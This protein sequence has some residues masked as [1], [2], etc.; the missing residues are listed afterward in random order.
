[1]TVQ[2]N[3]I[4]YPH[5][6][7]TAKFL[8]FFFSLRGRNLVRQ[9]LRSNGLICRNLRSHSPRTG[10]RNEMKSRIH[11]WKTYFAVIKKNAI[12]NLPCKVSNSRVKRIE[13]FCRKNNFQNDSQIGIP[14]LLL[15]CSQ[16]NTRIHG[17]SLDT[18]F[19]NVWILTQETNLLF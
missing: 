18:F 16:R 8:R 5:L 2:T 10:Q 19:P 7:N 9:L 11:L 13:K 3:I 1:M 15:I 17:V 4:P 6:R 12:H 14:G